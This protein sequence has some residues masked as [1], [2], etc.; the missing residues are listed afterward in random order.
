MG[1]TLPHNGTESLDD[2]DLIFPIELDANNQVEPVLSAVQQADMVRLA[3]IGRHSS[4][5]Q[6]SE[7]QKAA[8]RRIM[9]DEETTVRFLDAAI[10]CLYSDR[11]LAFVDD[12]NPG[13]PPL[14]VA[15]GYNPV[16]GYR[17]PMGAR[18]A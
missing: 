14:L 17:R 2:K 3:A 11:W 16:L 18:A 8:V 6:L 13:A 12:E 1:T 9:C 4:L 15:A 7:G 5:Q 10:V